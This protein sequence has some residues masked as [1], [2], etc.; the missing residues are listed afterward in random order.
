MAIRLQ[1]LLTVRTKADLVAGDAIVLVALGTAALTDEGAGRVV[2]G[3]RVDIV[4]GLLEYGRVV[5]QT[6]NTRQARPRL[7]KAAAG[8]C[9]VVF[10]A[11]GVV[12]EMSR[13]A[14]GVPQSV[15]PGRSLLLVGKESLKL[16]TGAHARYDLSLRVLHL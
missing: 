15:K 9:L 16:L 6:R 5:A 14:V 7:W 11:I 3:V 2:V 12:V 10:A 4:A 1:C 8:A 13:A